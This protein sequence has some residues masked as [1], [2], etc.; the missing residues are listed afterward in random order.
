MLPGPMMGPVKLTMGGVMGKVSI[1]L[2]MRGVMLGQLLAI[3]VLYNE[4]EI[5]N[6][7][8]IALISDGE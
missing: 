2:N 4:G 1:M 5:I 3:I 6:S 7:R 8:L